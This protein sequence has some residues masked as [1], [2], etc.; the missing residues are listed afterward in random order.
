[1]NNSHYK[2]NFKIQPTKEPFHFSIYSNGTNIFFVYPE[3]LNFTSEESLTFRYIMPFPSLAK[4]PY[5][6]FDSDY[7]ECED[8]NGLNKC[9]VPLKHFKGK[10]V[11]III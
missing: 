8:I 4:K 5:F 11:D 2:Y 7:L 10:K 1:M 9:N 6:V 3:I